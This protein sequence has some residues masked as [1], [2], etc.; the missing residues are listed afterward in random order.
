M[1][2]Q[3]DYRGFILHFSRRNDFV[4]RYV[5]PMRLLVMQINCE[6]YNFSWNYF[7]G[8]QINKVYIRRLFFLHCIMSIAFVSSH[9]P[10]D[11]FQ[12][13]FGSLVIID[14]LDYCNSMLADVS[15]TLWWRQLW[16]LRPGP[17]PD[18]TVLNIPVYRS[19]V[20]DFESRITFLVV[21][22]RRL[23]GI[24]LGFFSWN[25]SP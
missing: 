18:C 16:T 12:K 13:S 9:R 17:S 21:S 20:T 3:I 15:A 4:Y 11:I 25:S 23:C 7:A 22:Y 5:T 8:R 24:W 1:H 10:I 14:R 6:D 19:P 2:M